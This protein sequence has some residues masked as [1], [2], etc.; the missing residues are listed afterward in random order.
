MTW[1]PK[2]KAEQLFKNLFESKSNMAKELNLSRVTL[3]TYLSDPSLMNSQIKKIAKLK[4]ISE[5][6]LF[7]AINN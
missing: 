4:Q 7:K 3:D 6:K 5:L 2:N 1:T